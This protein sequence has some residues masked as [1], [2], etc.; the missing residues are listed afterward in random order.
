[1]AVANFEVRMFELQHCMK[2]LYIFSLQHMAGARI[3]TVVIMPF[4]LGTKISKPYS[5]TI[6]NYNTAERNINDDTQEGRNA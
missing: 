6:E 1:M 4:Y 5:R 3:G 2:R